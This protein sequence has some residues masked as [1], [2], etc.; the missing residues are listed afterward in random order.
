V[1][2]V[3]VGE[4]IKLKAVVYPDDK[5]SKQGEWSIG[6][7]TPKSGGTYKEKKF[8]KDFMVSGEKGEVVE[9]KG[10]ELKE[11]E[12]KFHWWDEGK[13]IKVK[14]KTVV[15]GKEVT[16]ES[17]F[18]VRKPV[19]TMSAETPQGVGGCYEFFDEEGKPLDHS[20]LLYLKKA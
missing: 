9:L 18:N 5:D 8:L 16:G 15:D 3:V 13:N 20:E 4:R 7:I 10:E 1:Q 11:P 2:D 12:I 14:Y 6:S 17:T 19:I